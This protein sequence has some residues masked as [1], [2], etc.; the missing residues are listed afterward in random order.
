[1]LPSALTWFFLTRPGSGIGTSDQFLPFQ[2]SA[3][4][5]MTWPPVVESSVP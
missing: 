5:L 1:M 3:W 4:F 2:C